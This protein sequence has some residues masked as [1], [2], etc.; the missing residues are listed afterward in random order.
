MQVFPQGKRTAVKKF[1]AARFFCLFP[2]HG[3]DFSR[4][5]VYNGLG[6]SVPI[7]DMVYRSA[8]EK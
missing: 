1:G 2:R 4:H 6:R 5:T 7:A 3:F 8:F